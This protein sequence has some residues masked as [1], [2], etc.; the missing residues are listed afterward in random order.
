MA[1]EKTPTNELHLTRV[2]HAPLAMVWNAWTDPEQT[3]HWWG[4]RGFTLTSHSHD[5]R[6]GGHWHYT[7]HGPDGTDYENTTVYHVVEPQQKLIYDHGG[8]KDRPPLFRVTVLF[9]FADGKTKMDMTMA[10]ATPEVAVEMG[11]FIRKA[12]GH[13]TWDRFTE[14]LDKK[15]N[16]K[17][18][19]V[20]NRSFDAPKDVVFAMWTNPEHLAN[21]LPPTGFEMAILDGS[22]RAGEAA[23]FRMSNPTDADATIHGRLEYL[24]I[25]SPNRIVYR[26]E[27]TDANG[28]TARHPKMPV[29]PAQWLNTIEFAD[30]ADEQTRVTVT[31]ETL[32]DVAPEDLQAFLDARGSMTQGWTG[33]FD[34]LEAIVDSRIQ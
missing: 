2:F 19:F 20:I 14:Y 34:K 6:V 23:F 11:K 17:N 9:S 32:K 30:E 24:V 22:I 31:T 12:G 5:L 13:S 10:F 8:H 1:K 25:D 26:Q 27:F 18:C 7:M 4:P 3:K 29:W 33:S 16:G 15:A 21:W 28:Q